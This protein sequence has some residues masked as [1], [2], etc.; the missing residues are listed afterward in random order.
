MFFS[1]II[2]KINAYRCFNGIILPPSI[3]NSYMTSFSPTFPSSS[4][5]LRIAQI[6][7]MTVSKEVPVKRL[8]IDIHLAEK[9]EYSGNTYDGRENTLQKL[10]TENSS[11]DK[12][13][14]KK[15]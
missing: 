2:I 3:Y 10:D 1:M 4:K 12:I 8:Q 11:D 15:R 9:F 13:I 14:N 7:T 5:H 6:K